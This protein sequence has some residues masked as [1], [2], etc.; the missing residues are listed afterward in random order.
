MSLC[1]CTR[2]I[3]KCINT[4]LSALSLDPLFFWLRLE[5]H[6][7]SA[8]ATHTH[9]LFFF[10]HVDFI[11]VL[12]FMYHARLI[13]THIRSQYPPRTILHKIFLNDRK[14]HHPASLYPHFFSILFF[15]FLP[16]IMEHRLIIFQKIN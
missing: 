15:F 11:I 5:W 2:F 4:F 8:T 7:L 6:S 14:K 3:Q 1:V 9:H 13:Q 10:R 12:M 16:Q